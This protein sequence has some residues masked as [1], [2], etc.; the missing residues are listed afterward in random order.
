M[1]SLTSDVLSV[2]DQLSVIHGKVQDLV[3]WSQLPAGKGKTF[4][5]VPQ[6]LV[7]YFSGYRGSASQEPGSTSV[8]SWQDFLSS[9]W[10]L[11]GWSSFQEE[12]CEPNFLE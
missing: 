1:P 6:D 3:K 4:V 9:L 5:P 7:I 2:A 8:Q 11:V 10:L 12:I